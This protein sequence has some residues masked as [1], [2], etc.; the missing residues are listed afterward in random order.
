VVGECHQDERQD[1]ERHRQDHKWNADHEKGH[2]KY[3]NRGSG[4]AS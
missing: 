1:C 2:R 3:R 4:S